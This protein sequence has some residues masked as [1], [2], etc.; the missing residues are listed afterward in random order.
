[1]RILELDQLRQFRKLIP[2]RKWLAGNSNYVL[3]RPKR[4]FGTS[5]QNCRTNSAIANQCLLALPRG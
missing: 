2:A 5:C 4:H 3:H 1:M